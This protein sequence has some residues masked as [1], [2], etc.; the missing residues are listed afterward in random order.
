VPPDLEGDRG[1]SHLNELAMNAARRS[2]STIAPVLARSGEGADETTGADLDEALA[3]R[4]A[5]RGAG[6]AARAGLNRRGQRN[7]L[8]AR[9]LI[10]SISLTEA[11]LD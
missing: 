4:S 5:W 3:G 8:S 2:R 6:Q 1:H 10:A 11:I 7:P 9:A